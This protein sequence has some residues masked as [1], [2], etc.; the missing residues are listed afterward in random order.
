MQPHQIITLY[1]TKPLEYVVAVLYMA[2]FAGFW[3]YVN[4]APWSF[5][6]AGAIAG[7]LADLFRIP[8]HVFFHPG[9]AWARAS[10]DGVITVGLDDFAQHL[11]G[12]V[13]AVSLPE[14]GSTVTAGSHAWTVG[15]GSKSVD[16]LAPVTG[17]VLAVNRALGTTPG[18]VNKDP[19][20]DG[21]LAK[22]QVASPP[23]ALRSLRCGRAARAWMDQIVSTITE[24]LS[25]GLGAICQD[26]GTPVEGL[27]HA[28]DPE[29]WDDVARRFLLSSSRP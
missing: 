3:R 27:A 17:T 2:L 9:H 5:A 11:V 6:G 4:G 13:T 19:Y 24:D 20:G 23:L 10:S 29:H 14:V 25:P 8:D 1:S 7:Q 16:M 28:L 12:P 15:A 26:G 22:L 18:L 21:W